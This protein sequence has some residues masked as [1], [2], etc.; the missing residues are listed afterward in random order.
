MAGNGYLM[1][2]RGYVNGWERIPSSSGDG[3]IRVGGRGEE[4]I[5]SK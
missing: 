3:P 2:R 5:P 4:N 1:A